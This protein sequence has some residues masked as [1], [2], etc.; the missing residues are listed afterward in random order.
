[1]QPY[2]HAS[3]WGCTEA[4]AYLHAYSAPGFALECPG[5]A[6]GH[7]GMTCV[8]DPTGC[9]SG[10]IIAIADPCAQSYM[11]EASNSWVLTGQ[12]DAPIDPYGACR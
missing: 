12:S 6:E 1:V 5:D 2:G 11:N 8:S 3:A 9:P 10:P 7:E 4:L